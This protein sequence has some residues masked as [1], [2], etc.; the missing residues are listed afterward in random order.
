MSTLTIEQANP[1]AVCLSCRYCN[2]KHGRCLLTGR[3][4]TK[5]NLAM[6]SNQCTG[7]KPKRRQT[8]AKRD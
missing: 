1:D 2:A 4:I 3:H 5:G 6:T 7:W 8:S